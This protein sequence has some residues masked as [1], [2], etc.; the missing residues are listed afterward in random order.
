MGNCTRPKIAQPMGTLQS[1][2]MLRLPLGATA[3]IMTHLAKEAVEKL[4]EHTF[5]S[6]KPSALPGDIHLEFVKEVHQGEEFT[7]LRFYTYTDTMLLE[8]PP[9]GGVD[10]QIPVYNIAPEQD[11]PIVGL[12]K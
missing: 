4:L 2:G 8:K 12:E 5:R 9:P 1:G 7:Y 11:F 3:E 6:L 10:N